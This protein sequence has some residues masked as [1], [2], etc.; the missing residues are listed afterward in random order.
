ME[1]ETKKILSKIHHLTIYELDIWKDRNFEFPI[2]IDI[3]NLLDKIAFDRI[4]S[5]T[6]CLVYWE[7]A[8]NLS[9]GEL[10][11]ARA[12]LGSLTESWLQFFLIIHIKDYNKN[13]IK[14]SKDKVVKVKN[15]SFNDL[16]EYIKNID[17]LDKY[18]EWI[19]SVQSKRNAIHSF[20]FKKLGDNQDFINDLV[21]YQKFLKELSNRLPF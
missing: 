12:N 18:Y 13:P 19:G 8:K 4:K 7:D 21:E 6:E 9:V 17:G 5:L 10:I 2:P 11:L 1:S 16:K 20:T 14:D 15:I 3:R